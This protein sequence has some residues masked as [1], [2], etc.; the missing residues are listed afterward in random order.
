MRASVSP[1]DPV[2]ISA[3]IGLDLGALSGEEIALSIMAELV[4]VRYARDGTRLLQRRDENI[5]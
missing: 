3:P 5:H 1:R 2:R 4:A